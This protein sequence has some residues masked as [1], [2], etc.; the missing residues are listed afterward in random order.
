MLRRVFLGDNDTVLRLVE[1]KD[2]SGAPYA[3]HHVSLSLYDADGSVAIASVYADVGA[4]ML[5]DKEE[6]ERQLNNIDKELGCV[7]QVKAELINFE[8]SVYETKRILIDAHTKLVAKITPGSTLTTA[9]P[10]EV[11]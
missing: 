7:A 6:I 5:T 11:E 1:E 2:M 9:D 3:S 10:D 8:M 4:G